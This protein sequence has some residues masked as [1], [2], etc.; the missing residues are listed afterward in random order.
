MF[1]REMKRRTNPPATRMIKVEIKL[2]KVDDSKVE[3]VSTLS[4]ATDVE[5]KDTHPENV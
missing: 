1:P 3:D 4:S 2:D 5:W